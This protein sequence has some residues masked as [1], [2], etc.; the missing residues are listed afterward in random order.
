MKSTFHLL[1]GS[2]KSWKVWSSS[3]FELENYFVTVE[4]KSPFS[5]HRRGL[6]RWPWGSKPTVKPAEPY[7]QKTPTKTCNEFVVLRVSV[8]AVNMIT[9]S[10]PLPAAPGSSTSHLNNVQDFFLL[11]TRLCREPPAGLWMRDR[12]SQLVM[13]EN[14]FALYCGSALRM[15]AA[16]R[17]T[18]GQTN[19][20]FLTGLFRTGSA[21]VTL[22]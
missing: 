22:K 2:V 13:S 4:T 1:S 21:L 6:L 10:L 5:G 17:I 14:G 15:E 12:Q 18:T 11:W 3:V 16:S 19:S 9:W 7:T 20:P 8:G